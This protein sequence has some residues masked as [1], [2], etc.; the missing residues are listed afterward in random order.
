MSLWGKKILPMLA[1]LSDPFDSKEWIFEIKFDGTR[2]I[3]YLDLEKNYV[4]FL[5]RRGIFFE[6]RYPEI[7]K[8]LANNV[9]A[10]RIILDGEIC[11]FSEGKPDFYK[12]AERE[13][14]D[15]KLRI[16]LLSK[17][18]PATFI[19]FDVLHLNGKDLIDL[20]LMERKEILKKVINEGEK[21]LLSVWIEEKGVK[22]FKEV[23]EKGLEGIVAKKKDS[24]YEIGKRS[25]NWLKIK[26][27]K[28]L[29]C[30]VLGYTKGEGIRE[31]YF[32][33][34]LCGAYFKNKL[35]YLGK[36]GTGFSEF[37]LKLLTSLLKNMET[38]KK[39][40]EGGEEIEEEVSYVKPKLVVEVS[41][42]NLTKDLKFRAP[43]FKKIRSDK[44]PSE[45]ILEEKDLAFLL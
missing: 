42:M 25:K 41:F 22:F 31:E 33:A 35:I 2:T 27:L 19:I 32:G 45:C 44:K 11:V 23:K 24:K 20:P 4:R 10:K 37:D 29:D 13:Q 15:N 43:S 18:M 36:V 7:V 8:D 12:L 9:N 30:I 26:V 14:V 5:N 39:Y 3:A 17:M 34:L 28:T 6:K 1:F 38:S 40:F 21:I 16:E